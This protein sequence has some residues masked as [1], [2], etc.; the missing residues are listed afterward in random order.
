MCP[1][2]EKVRK[3]LDELK[4]NFEKINV[5]MSRNDPLRKKLLEKSGIGS[6]P[7]I[8]DQGKFVGDSEKIIKYLEKTYA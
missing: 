4:L 1:Y 7:V 5:P 6:V 3:K 2:C 8:E